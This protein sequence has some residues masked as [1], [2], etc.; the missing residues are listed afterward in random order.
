MG[1]VTSP[2]SEKAKVNQEQE[3]YTQGKVDQFNNESEGYDANA[4]SK[5]EGT[6]KYVQDTSGQS[7]N[8]HNQN[9]NYAVGGGEYGRFNNR[10]YG[11]TLRLAR[12]ADA[13]NNKPV[14]QM[15]SV[16]TRH[17]GGVKNL[18]TG[19][20]R[21][22]IQTMETRAMDQAQQLDTAQK[23]LAQQL[24]AAINRKDLDAFI[25]AYQQMYGI[26]LDQYHAQL[27]MTQMA[28]QLQT[29][30]MLTKDMAEWQSYFTRAFSASTAA[31][32]TNLIG[33]NPMFATYLSYY[34]TGQA[35]PEQSEYVSS[36]IETAR[37]EDLMR[38]QGMDYRTALSQAH[39]ETTRF[40]Q[41]E[42]N[43]SMY[44]SAYNNRYFGAGGRR[45]Q[46]KAD[47][48]ERKNK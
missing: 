4:K 6:Y 37:A 48:A 5:T 9:S 10:D 44:D 36:Q 12:E 1:E 14:N 11:L 3:Q 42:L 19:Y 23:S 17:T 21:P 25:A 47:K 26:T 35:T 13:Y 34:L 22:R 43:K 28:R 18:G 29:Q 32:I 2:F 15:F 7:I 30:Q 16:G 46:K 31:T 20:E 39:R 45:E 41:Q 27:A 8:P 38:T 33:T 24:Q 40:Y